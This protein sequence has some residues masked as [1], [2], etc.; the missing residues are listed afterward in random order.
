MQTLGVHVQRHVD[1]VN[2]TGALA[3]AE[4]AAFDAV[5]PGHQAQLGRGYTGAA[6]VVGVQADQHAVAAA[7]V[8]AEP[9][10]LVGVNVR[11]GDLDGSRQVEDHLVLGRRL[12]DVEHGITDL[13]GEV[14]FG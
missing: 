2:I 9:F 3:V 4:Q 6:I 1:Q 7:D 10:D 14:Q 8:A 5:S 12:P 13:N 11:S